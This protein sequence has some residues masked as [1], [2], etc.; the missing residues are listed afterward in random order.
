M[1]SFKHIVWM[2]VVL[3]SCGMSSSVHSAESN[4]RVKDSVPEYVLV[5]HGGAGSLNRENTSD[6]MD[7]M[8]RE[9]I[10]RVLTEG[11]EMLETG[12]SAVDVVE[13]VIRVMEDDPMFNAGKGS[14]F[15]YEGTNEMDASIMR[16]EDLGAGA[17]AGIKRVKNPISAARKVMEESVHVMLSRDGAEAFCRSQGLEMV[18]PEYFDTE[19]KMKVL[20]RVQSRKDGQGFLDH[21]N[22]DEKWGTVGAVALD[23]NGNLA[24]GTSTG[25]MTNKRYARIGDSPI[26]GAG[27]YADNNSVAVSCTG[28]GEYYIRYAVAHD[29]SAR[30]KYTGQSVVEAAD[31]IIH[32]VLKKAGGA[33]GLIAVD[34]KGQVALPFNT[35]GMPR[36]YINPEE[37]KVLLYGDE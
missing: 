9:A 18:D 22:P 12:K 13:Y 28:H 30:I 2:A 4:H 24:A 5:V 36:G 10:D 3:L 25:G 32:G 37:K 7:S 1:K 14:V 35:A 31:E 8:Y 11:G 27:T 20:K 16:G 23:K 29:L 26:I 33:G 21:I 19:S 15:T 6:K 17:V 34:H